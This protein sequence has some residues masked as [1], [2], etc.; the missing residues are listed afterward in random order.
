LHNFF[1]KIAKKNA[2][3]IK[4]ILSRIFTTLIFLI[5]LNFGQFFNYSVFPEKEKQ[6]NLKSLRD[7]GPKEE[8]GQLQPV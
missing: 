6:K 4:L 7:F 1:S 8:Y 2:T 3:E 5:I